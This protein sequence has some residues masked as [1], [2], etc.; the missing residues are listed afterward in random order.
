MREWLLLTE[1]ESEWK[2]LNGESNVSLA[3][4]IRFTDVLLLLIL[5]Y[6]I[7]LVIYPVRLRLKHNMQIQL[8]RA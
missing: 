2:G 7:K 4:T 3:T 8:L 5:H 1:G 6:M